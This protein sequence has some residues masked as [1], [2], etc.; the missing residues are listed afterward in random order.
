MPRLLR[1]GAVVD[2]PFVLVRE[3][4][5]LADL[6]EA[7]PVIVPIR[8][9]VVQPRQEVPTSLYRSMRDDRWH[10]LVIVSPL[11][12]YPLAPLRCLPSPR[13]HGMIDGWHVVEYKRRLGEGPTDSLSRTR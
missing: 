6:P 5:S 13:N 7:T 3:A 9:R 8:V 10:L 12:G 11:Y 2:D 1:F 4:D